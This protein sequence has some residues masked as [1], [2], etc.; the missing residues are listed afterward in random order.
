MRQILLKK[1]CLNKSKKK[2]R[3]KRKAP[4]FGFRP[5]YDNSNFQTLDT[6]WITRW[7][8]RHSDHTKRGKKLHLKDWNQ[9][10]KL[11]LYSSLIRC[12]IHLSIHIEYKKYIS[13][14]ASIL[15]R[16]LYFPSAFR[17]P[18]AA[19]NFVLLRVLDLC[20]H[21]FFSVPPIFF[22]TSEDFRVSLYSET[23]A[24][25]SV[26][27]RERISP[28]IQPPVSTDLISIDEI[29]LCL[30][31]SSYFFSLLYSFTELCDFSFYYCC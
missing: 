18:S 16:Q 10:F 2:K 6:G 12:K 22:A 29:N 21:F 8:I 30:I 5:Y 19:S 11:F 1:K 7:P 26:G 17:S 9:S 4:I 23:N 14:T 13:V 31:P 20:F 15:N 27:N 24:Q 3:R 25:T 28:T